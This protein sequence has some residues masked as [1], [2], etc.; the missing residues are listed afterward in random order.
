[1]A[2]ASNLVESPDGVKIDVPK[3]MGSPLAASAK[4]SDSPGT[5]ASSLLDYRAVGYWLARLLHSTRAA[6]IC[7]KVM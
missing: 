7:G 4:S 3:T 5:E 6:R 2:A 1:M